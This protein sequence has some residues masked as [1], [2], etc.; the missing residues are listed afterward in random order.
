MVD[1]E[2]IL[3]EMN[4]INVVNN[5]E[6]TIVDPINTNDIDLYSCKPNEK[7]LHQTRIPGD[8]NNSNNISYMEINKNCFD[9]STKDN[10]Y[11]K[12]NDILEKI[13]NQLHAKKSFING[14]N[15]A[16]SS[17]PHEN[18]HRIFITNGYLKEFEQNNKMELL[19]HMKC[20]NHLTTS[21][22]ESELSISADCHLINHDDSNNTAHI[23]N[24]TP[25]SP[26]QKY[27]PRPFITEEE[28]VISR[29]YH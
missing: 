27:P 14:D 12:I 28:K 19:Q 8:D 22:N 1:N 23:T 9:E 4:T 18:T 15:H 2:N 20:N 10:S 29:K 24:C 21:L 16:Y 7:E 13:D 17:C 3:H 11:R 5:V 6:S 26:V 25:L